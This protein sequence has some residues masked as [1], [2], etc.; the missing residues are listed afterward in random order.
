MEKIVDLKDKRDSLGTKTTEVCFVLPTYNEEK[1]IR[2]TVEGIFSNQILVPTSRFRVL[3]VD[4]NSSDGTQKEVTQLIAKYPDLHMITGDKKG[5]GDAYKRGLLYALSSFKPDFVFQMD[6]DGQHDPKLIPAFIEQINAGYSLV[7]GSRFVEGGSTPDFSFRRKF[8]SRL[9]NLLVRYAGGVRHIRDC[10][11]GYR[12]ISSSHLEKCNL[13]FLSTRGY[14]FQSSLICELVVQGAKCKEIPITFSRRN[15]GSSKLSLRDQVEFILNIPKLGFHSHKDFIKY[16]TVGFSGLFV[17]LGSYIF[18][19]RYLGMAEVVAPI[20][21]IETSLI[22]N[23]LLNNFWTFRKRNL[24]RALISR[25]MQFHLVM[26]FTGI[27]NYLTFFL[28][29]KIVMV[30]DILANLL[31]IGVAA[32]LNYLINSNWTWKK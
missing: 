13:G 3:V 23:F 27:F 21:S 12:C 10:T 16:S 15:S 8:I 4:D 18:L 11:S 2:Q 30:N 32:I 6:S 7:V 14:S 20:I 29:F 26:G 31:G 19:T 17:N 24:E 25:L 28:M 9:G 1:N 22:S 5:L